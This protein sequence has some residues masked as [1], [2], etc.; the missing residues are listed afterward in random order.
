MM[1]NCLPPSFQSLT[2]KQNQLL[3]S[4]FERQTTIGKW[5]TRPFWVE[6]FET[7]N[8]WCFRDQP[9]QKTKNVFCF[10]CWKEFRSQIKRNFTNTEDIWFEIE[11]HGRQHLKESGLEFFL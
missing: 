10:L 5:K 4:L 8:G 2:E 6:R 9:S 1:T 11:E 7:I 3:T